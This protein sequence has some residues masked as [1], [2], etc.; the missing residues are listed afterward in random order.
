MAISGNGCPG[1]MPL[2]ALS[3]LERELNY[4]FGPAESLPAGLGM[5]ERRYRFTPTGM[6][7]FR[8]FS[9]GL[10]VAMPIDTRINLECGFD[11]LIVPSIGSNQSGKES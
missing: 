3:V 1:A 2:N 11:D 10:T 5:I 4:E 9:V 7:G 6:G 8:L